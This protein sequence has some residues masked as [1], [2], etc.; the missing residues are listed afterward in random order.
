[1][2]E[3][4]PQQQLTSQISSLQYKVRNLQS[5]VRLASLRDSVEDLDVQVNGLK[6]RVQDLRFKGYVFGKSLEAKANDYARRW[7]AQRVSV[8]AEI[9]RQCPSLERELRPLESQLSVLQS[10]AS[11]P[12]LGLPM[13]ERL[14]STLGTFDSKVGAVENSIRGMFDSLLNEVN[15]LKAEMDRIQWMLEQL[16]QACFQLLA[17][18]GS[19]MAVKATYSRDAKMDKEDPQGVLFL[20]DQRLIFEQKQE[21]ATKKI[22]FFATEKQKVQQQLL[23]VPVA[24]V[25]KVEAS[26]KG[27]FGHQDHL[28]ITFRSGAPVR[29]AW[30]HLDGQDC[31]WWN[32]LIG[33][34]RSGEFDDERA[35]KIDKEVKEKVKSAPS[36][37]PGC[38]APITQT[39]LRGMDMLTCEYCQHVIRL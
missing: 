5:K 6:Q 11:N 31:N 18:E 9:D 24:L 36:N 19:I 34:A 15:Q 1:M 30:F 37:C 32:G 38:G 20:T 35:V 22:L 16:A 17:T 25:E 33:Q 23:E 10:R 29:S 3:Q 28:T 13:A 12:R 14:E 21:V 4:T 39:V 26:K 27:L 7:R 2:T 8:L